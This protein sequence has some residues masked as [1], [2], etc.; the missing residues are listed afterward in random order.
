MFEA[1]KANKV[2]KI[3]ET[4]AD[5]YR[6]DGYDIYD[7]GILQMHAVGK[8]VPIEE[9]EKVCEELKQVKKQLAA[10]KRQAKK[11]D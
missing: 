4:E 1:R 7:G 6:A 11:A 2:Y 10:A 3:D 5:R 9:H 8:T